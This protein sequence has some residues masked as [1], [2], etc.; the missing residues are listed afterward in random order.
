MLYAVGLFIGLFGYSFFGGGQID[1]NRIFMVPLIGAAIIFMVLSIFTK[2]GE[3][4]EAEQ[5]DQE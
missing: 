2:R 4:T 1:W 3:S 5:T